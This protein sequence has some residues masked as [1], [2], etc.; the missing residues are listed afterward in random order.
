MGHGFRV[1]RLE[2]GEIREV[3]AILGQ[4]ESLALRLSPAPSPARLEQLREID[5]RLERT[6]GDA[7][8]CLDL[9]DEWHRTLLQEC[10][11]Q[12]LVDLILSLRQVP[13]RYL[14]A[15]MRDA[16]RITLST[17][18]HAR[19]LR[20]LEDDGSDSGAAVFDHQWRRAIAELEAW[21]S[22]TGAG[23]ST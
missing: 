16:G 17:Q 1:R 18:P 8:A 4:L 10:P 2:P 6:R 14:A 5:R 23:V 11:N 21:S 22:R 3:G 15:Y 12:R 13:R 19:I 20:A 9:E 7:S